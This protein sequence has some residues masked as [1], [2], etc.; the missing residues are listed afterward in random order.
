MHPIYTIQTE[1]KLLTFDRP[2][3]MGIL[4]VTPDSFYDGGRYTNES[5]MEQRIDQI[6]SEGADVIDIGGMSSR[7][8]AGTIPEEIETERVC[9]AI[10]K[11]KAR[12][13][14]AIISVDTFR[15]AVAK[16]AVA[17]GAGIINDIS[18]GDLDSNMFSC[19]REL[20]IPYILMHM[21]GDPKTMTQFTDY[22]NVTLDVLDSLIEK[23]SRLRSMGIKDIIIDPGFGFSKNISQNFELLSKLH[24]FTML[25][26]PILVGLSRKS[27]I[28][29]TLGISPEEALNGTTALHMA[30][31][32]EG[33]GML[34][35]HDVKEAKETIS[36]FMKMKTCN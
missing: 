11:V 34:R 7:P 21:R 6:I 18:G 36:L 16:N 26:C 3:I 14:D 19:I 20:N 33:A 22:K 1:G 31:L 13:P 15:S 10:T 27:M 5:G 24:V 30:A 8:G 12:H 32:L 23:V 2:R 28:F 25:D 29:K 35:V 9:R 17:S 4:N